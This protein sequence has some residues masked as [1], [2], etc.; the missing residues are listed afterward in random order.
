MMASRAGRGGALTAAAAAPSRAAGAQ[1][2]H[3]HVVSCTS[4]AMLGSRLARQTGAG[5]GRPVRD[6]CVSARR[7]THK[8]KL[9]T[10]FVEPQHDGEDLA[11]S[12]PRV[13]RALRF[14]CI[15]QFVGPILDAFSYILLLNVD[16]KALLRLHRKVLTDKSRSSSCGKSQI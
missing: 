12:R 4:L 7:T 9:G 16:N 13:F 8:H 10:H 11:D 14:R 5:S 3:T 15:V 2:Q 6:G 1:G